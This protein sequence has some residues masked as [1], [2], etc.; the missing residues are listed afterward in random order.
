MISLAS[1]VESSALSYLTA[2]AG[3]TFQLNATA[4]SLGAIPAI[5][6][7]SVTIGSASAEIME[8]SIVLAYPVFVLQCEKL[9]NTLKEKFRVFSGTAQLTVDVR[10]SQDQIGGITAVLQ[11]YASA[12]CQ[13]FDGAR[14]D[15]GNGLFYRGGYEVAFTAIRK[16]GKGF[17][18][19]AK[20]ALSI[21]ISI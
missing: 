3:S 18:Q 20:V 2:P 16:G 15:W 4:Q 21:D 19:A 7:Q 17:L 8:Q 14:G 6:V 10:Y 13:I 11:K 12:A 1:T 9:S 5:L